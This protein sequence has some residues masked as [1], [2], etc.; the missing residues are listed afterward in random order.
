VSISDWI[1]ANLGPNNR[2]IASKADAKILGAYDQ[3]P[4]TD[5]ASSI[6]TMFYAE[7]IGPAETH[8]LLKR[9]VEYVVMDRKVVSWDNM[10]G[11]YYY[12]PEGLKLF[13]PQIV[14]KFDDLEG[15]NRLLDSGDIVVFDVKNYLAAQSEENKSTSPSGRLP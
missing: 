12:K 4:F 6:R 14:N 13:D 11:Y 5:T 10:I 3:H 15:V 9:D 8:T 2:I 1:L 7:S